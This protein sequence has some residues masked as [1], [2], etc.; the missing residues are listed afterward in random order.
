MAK[1]LVRQDS[2]TAHRASNFADLDL[3]NMDPLRECTKGFDSKDSSDT[4]HSFEG[5]EREDA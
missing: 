4:I 2:V 3:M 5:E 1:K